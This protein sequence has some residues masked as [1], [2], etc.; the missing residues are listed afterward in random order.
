[1]GRE[2]SDQDG[3]GDGGDVGD[4][5]NEMSVELDSSGTV[6]TQSR[7]HTL[8]KRFGFMTLGAMVLLRPHSPR[9]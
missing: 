6:V 8:E 1:M 3:A 7:H 5:G 4:E 9:L 2:Q